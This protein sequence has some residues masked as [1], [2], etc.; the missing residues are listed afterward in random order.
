MVAEAALPKASKQAE[1]QRHK[2][3]AVH[4]THPLPLILSAVL[5]AG[6]GRSHSAWP[7]Q[8]GDAGDKAHP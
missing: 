2:M 3:V 7:W 1:S 8:A 4:K 5:L 6:V